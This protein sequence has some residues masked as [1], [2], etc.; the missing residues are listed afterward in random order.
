MRILLVGRIGVRLLIFVAR[1]VRI[2][3]RGLRGIRR[4]VG[5][6]RWWIGGAAAE[7]PVED[8]PRC[9]CTTVPMVLV[10]AVITTA[11]S[12][13]VVLVS[14]FTVVVAAAIALIATAASAL[15]VRSR[16][17]IHRTRTVVLSLVVVLVFIRVRCERTHSAE[18]ASAQTTTRRFIV[19]L[20]LGRV[21]ALSMPVWKPS[22]ALYRARVVASL[23]R[24]Y[25]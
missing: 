4:L 10:V 6:I 19:C 13:F 22:L 23:L 14:T 20:P 8:S 15:A 11:V 3:V 25:Q 2:R 1:P 9:G 5:R 24:R 7:D 16:W 21:L 12:P 17:I 18:N